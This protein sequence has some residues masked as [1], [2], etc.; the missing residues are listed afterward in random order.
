M[1]I[2]AVEVSFS[3]DDHPWLLPMIE[4]SARNTGAGETA[5]LA[6]AGYYSGANLVACESGGQ[7]GGWLPTTRSN[8][9]TKLRPT[10]TSTP[11]GRGWSS[12]NR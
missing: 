1:L 11:K 9:F 5:T 7:G 6:D 2:T 3:S 4:E 10:P 12:W 8:S